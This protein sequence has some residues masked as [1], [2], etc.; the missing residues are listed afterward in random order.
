MTKELQLS[1]GQKIDLK[2]DDTCI[3]V[4]SGKVEVYA[5]TRGDSSFRQCF[6]TEIEKGE[7]AFAAMDEDFEAV[8]TKLYATEDSVIAVV[9]FAEMPKDELCEAMRL[10]LNKLSA[11]PWLAVMADKGDD[12]LLA[13]RNKTGLHDADTKEKIIEDFKNHEQIFAM[14]LGVRFGAEDKRLARRV[15]IRENGKRLMI[16]NGIRSLMGE[17]TLMVGA[18]NASDK[19]TASEAVFI[20]RT[21]AKALKMPDDSIYIAD[22]I[23][24]RLDEIALLRRLM[25]KGRMQMR[26]ITLPKGW[27]E[28]DTGV[29]LGFYG[30]ERELAA[31]VPVAPNRYRV[32]TRKHPEGFSLTKEH[33]EKLST[34]AFACYAG[35]P[36]RAL[37]IFDLMK[38][39]FY[40][41]WKADYRV[42]ILASFFAGLIPLATPV[43]TETIFQDIIPI[44]DRQGLATVTQVLLVT[45]FTTA[46]LSIV[47]SIAVMRIGT[48]IEMS[49]EAAMW[50][51]LMQLPTKFFRRYTVGELASRM[52]GISVAKSLV[53]G[54]FVG[55]V[56]GLLFSFWSIFLMCYYSLKLTAAAV[57]VWIVYGIFVAFVYRRV[58]FFQRKIIESGNRAAGTVQQI[59]A[60]LSKFRVQGAEEQAYRLWTRDFGEQWN[61]RLKLRWQNNYTSIIAS[62]QPFVLTMILYIIAVYGM[63][64]V[65]A[66]GKTVTTGIGYAQFLAFNSAYSSFN[67]VL[68]G[69]IGLIGQYFGIQPHL[70]N[71]RPILQE[72]PESVGDKEDAGVLSGAFSVSNLSFAYENGTEVLHDVNFSV[73]AGEHVAIV[74]KSGSGKSTLVRLLLGFETPTKGSVYFD[75]QDL[76]DLNLPSVRSQM[77]VVLQ[78]GQLMTGDIYTNIVGTRLLSQDEAWQA[79][80]AAGIAED[81][82]MMPMGMQTII[83]EGSSN[84]SGG[85]RQR[86]L[87]ARAL[88]TKPSILILDE[89]TSALDNSSQAIVTNSLDKMKTTRIVVA[90]RLSTIRGCDRI[91][92][93]DDGRIAETGGFDEL[94]AKNGIFAELV[95]RQVV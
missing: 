23:A 83:S 33:L 19:K 82:A 2:N 79:A 65:S 75:G 53:S 60:G 21:I 76:A 10:W 47:R 20:V 51:R 91:I 49:A 86:I 59:F 93:M 6:L 31:L 57:V 40:Q 44:L 46:T 71:V 50:G 43:I 48:R 17:E 68:G 32:I 42:I 55:S 81:I 38:F 61:W 18:N 35:F 92:V 95:K 77:G 36:A 63:E 1:V 24:N 66:D 3:T 62:I 8:E 26:L 5:V 25:Q 13:W 67:S 15:K 88:A 30:Q 41:C 7:S 52:G 94:V 74:G 72:I 9:P 29:I 28:K 39:M 14:Y 56:M 84:I 12:V 11:I 70:E 54:E 22:D 16:E 90:H 69:V 58:L 85:Q 73:T 34:D 80:E 64:E 45:S 27:H 89:A 4:L 37:T 87:I 78:N